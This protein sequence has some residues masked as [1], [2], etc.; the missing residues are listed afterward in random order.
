MKTDINNN[1]D[2]Y[3]DAETGEVTES[4]HEAVQW[5]AEGKTI[6]LYKNNEKKLTWTH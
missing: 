3:M 4:H 2:F 5:F 6:E 1:V